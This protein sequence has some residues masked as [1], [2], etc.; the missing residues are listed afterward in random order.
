MRYNIKTGVIQS[1]SAAEW[2]ALSP[3]VQADWRAYVAPVPGSVTRRQLLLW[4]NARGVTRAGI[5]QV[6]A[7]LPVDARESASIEFDEAKD[8]D[9]SHPLVSQL[10]AAFGLSSADIDEGFRIAAYL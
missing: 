2:S 6:L 10:G 5:R 8:F 3:A 9:R 4:L 1:F 7:G